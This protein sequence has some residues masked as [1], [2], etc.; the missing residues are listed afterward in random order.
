MVPIPNPTNG[1]V[2]LIIEYSQV[3]E[4]T[5]EYQIEVIDIYGKHFLSQKSTNLSTVLDLSTFQNGMYKVVV[6]IDE[7]V[8]S[9]TLNISR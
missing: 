5:V 3:V 1:F 7:Q 8:L 4:R 6:L 2:N 9:Q